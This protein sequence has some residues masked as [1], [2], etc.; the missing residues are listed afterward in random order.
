[1]L[2]THS[3]HIAFEPEAKVSALAISMS[4]DVAVWAEAGGKLFIAQNSDGLLKPST[5]WQAP[6]LIRKAIIRGNQVFVLDDEYGLTCLN[7]EGTPLWQIE[8]GA[9]GFGLHQLPSQLAIIDGLG[10]LQMFGY[11]GKPIELHGEFK[12]IL[13][14]IAIG[15]YLILAHES[16]QVQAL[17]NGTT[18]WSRPIRGD[19]GESI[20]CLGSDASQNLVIGREGYALVSGDE[21]VLEIEIWDLKQNVLIYR[22]DLKSR[23]LHA[24]PA[25]KGLFCGFDNGQVS[26][27]FPGQPSYTFEPRIASSYPIQNLLFRNGCIAASSWFYIYGLDANGREWKI[28]HQGMPHFLEASRDGSVCL[29]AGEDQNDWTDIEPIGSFSFS[30]EVIE[31]DESELTLWFEKT[32][33]TVQLSAEELY[34][35]DDEMNSFFSEDELESMQN[36]QPADVGLDA[37]HDALEGDFGE[38]QQASEDGALDIDTEDLLAQLDDAITQ[39]ALL[40]SEDLL[41]ELNTEIGEVIVP[42]AVSGEDQHLKADAD[43]SAIITLDGSNSFDPQERI[44]TWSWIESSGKEIASSAKVRVRIPRGSHNFELRICD[45]DGQWSSDSLHILI[46]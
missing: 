18:V 37:L 11:D 44:H 35:V 43:G 9:G 2:S 19:T 42:R 14:C 31:I 5:S 33:E 46:E 39:M 41:E 25:E 1:M 26:E 3:V 15:E 38:S 17:Q 12:D 16:G 27:Y 36:T 40:P 6:A 29:F 32:E 28:E 7:L 4:G 34:R 45:R 24:I 8:I 13:R 23:L 22:D 21:E 30:E 10:R 20:T